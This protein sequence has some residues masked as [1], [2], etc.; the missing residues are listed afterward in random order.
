MCVRI[1]VIVKYFGFESEASLDAFED[2]LAADV[3]P[4]DLHGQEEIVTV[5]FASY[6]GSFAVANLG[7]LS[8]DHLV[9]FE[10]TNQIEYCFSFYFT[11]Y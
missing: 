5:D 9:A 7:P 4:D 2:L 6:L 3:R 10:Q 11:S 1:I 8:G